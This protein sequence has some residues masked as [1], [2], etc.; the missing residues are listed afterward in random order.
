[1]MNELRQLKRKLLNQKAPSPIVPVNFGIKTGTGTYI[2]QPRRLEGQQYVTV[3][4]NT[5]MGKEAWLSAYDSYPHSGQTFNPEI[6]IGNN[7]IIGSFATITAINKIIIEDC[8]EISDFL[9]M[10]DH[11][12]DITPREGVQI[13]RR[14]LIS[15]GYV[16]IGAYTALGIY[17]TIL[18]GVTLGKYCVVGAHSV[19]TRSFPDYSI[20]MG[21]PA[22]VVRTYSPETQKWI[23]PKGQEVED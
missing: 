19:V 18:P 6:S 8:V 20:L 10:S 7:C 1:M 13:S 22:V 17:V 15:R 12:H 16:K 14:R 4:D 9:Y 5:Y 3:G 23:I 2:G 21:N 11:V